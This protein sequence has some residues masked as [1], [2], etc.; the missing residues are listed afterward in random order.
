LV[1]HVVS[2]SLSRPAAKAVSNMVFIASRLGG[3]V[4]GSGGR[5]GRWVPSTVH[6]S[7][8]VQRLARRES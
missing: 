6:N 8:M 5:L 2:S 1:Y 7:S 3:V 4:F